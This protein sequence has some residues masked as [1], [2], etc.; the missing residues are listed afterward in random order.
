MKTVKVGMIGLNNGHARQYFPFLLKSPMFDFVGVSVAPDQRGRAYLGMIPNVPVYASPE[1]LIAAHPELEAMI[2]AGPN[3]QT[4]GWMKFCVAHHLHIYL[5]KVPTMQ[6]DEY[7]E[8]QKLAAS[9]DRVI[10]VE[11]QMRF[12]AM[13]RKLKKLIDEGAVGNLISIHATNM[14]H[15]V[16]SWFVWAGD[17]TGS[18][19]KEVPLFPGSQLVRGGSM[20]D[21]PHTFDMM[22]YLTGSEYEFVY[23][24]CAPN[25]RKE[26][27]VEDMS[28]VVGR[29][30]NGVLISLDPSYSRLENSGLPQGSVSPGWEQYPRRVEVNYTVTGD[31]GVIL[32][33]CYNSGMYHT[34]NPNHSYTMMPSHED[35]HFDRMM[36]DFYLSIVEGKK[37]V[38]TLESH[39]KTIEVMNA[40]YESV[41]T[42]APVY[43]K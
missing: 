36:E 35:Y 9:T 14:T 6:M 23:A 8:M 32:V 18:Y 13:T 1:E 28:F 29:M 37:T 16:C 25:L 2:I 7:D 38:V 34:A 24:D 5:M 15:S 19:G 39:R 10:Q 22:R 33:D 12:V 40:C 42:G 21:H 41:Y 4:L 11:Q 27:K 30:K 20:T 26:L 3:Y 31:K 17:G 43:L